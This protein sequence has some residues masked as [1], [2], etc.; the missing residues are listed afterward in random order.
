MRIPGP[1][2]GRTR[3]IG[4]VA[5][6]AALAG[7]I[8]WFVSAQQA[9]RP[10]VSLSTVTRARITDSVVAVGDIK[11]V[12]RATITLSPTTKVEYVPVQVGQ[13]VA[14]GD[15]LVV[16]DTTE[17]AHQLEQQGITL[18]D[19]RSALR[20]LSGP[21]ARMNTATADNA[22]KQASI[23]LEN[24]RAAESAARRHLSEVPDSNSTAI[25]Q[26]KIAL[27]SARVNADAASANLESTRR[28]NE[29]AVR[30]A[31]ITFDAA[32]TTLEAAER[33]LADLNAQLQAGLITQAEYDARYPA[34]RAA[35]TT[36]ETAFRSAR[37]GLDTA[38]A[39]ADAAITNAERA[40]S[41]ADL[42]VSSAK[43]ALSGV[44]QQADSQLRAARSAVADA[45]RAVDSAKVAL[46]GAR[47][48]AGYARASAGRSEAGQ[49]SQVDQIEST[50]DYLRDRIDQGT[51]RAPL[52][53]VVSRVDAEPGQFPQLGD[54]IVVQGTAGYLAS[55]EVDQT[56]SVGIEPGQ[57]ATVRLKGIGVEMKGSVASVA[58]VAERST[59]SA[60][61]SPLVKIEVAIPDPDPALRIGFEADVEI[62]RD[63]R[64]DAL[65]VRA[66]ALR[67]EPGTGRR[68]VFVVDE[69]RHVSRVFVT[70]GIESGDRVEVVSGV[71]EGQRLVVDPPDSL[72][73]GMTV[74]IVGGG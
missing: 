17:Y 53:G 45:R 34:L 6:V 10:A 55:V 36:A 69:Q 31:K 52:S 43:A 7:G 64:P 66:D 33:D 3:L 74:R 5:A 35:L 20:Y 29:N 47:S 12:D 73:D 42:A 39:T 59:T 15:V 32:E 8:F 50:I 68:Y 21:S 14:R 28:L 44:R 71:S 56:D 11:S 40:A 54:L 19:A 1:G 57:R 65:E 38:R 16:L 18:T 49:R 63:D 25:H 24:A 62:F 60:D 61:N 51:L 46:S 70:T 58:P 2:S 4:V 72:A 37:V 26:A 41:E 48:G 9:G 22:V 30:Q 67:S 23:A 13:R 27:D